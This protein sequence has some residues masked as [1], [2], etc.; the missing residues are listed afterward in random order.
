[1]SS[2]SSN[3]NQAPLDALADRIRAGIE[4][5]GVHLVFEDELSVIWGYQNMKPVHERSMAVKN[6]ANLYQLEV[7]V[8]ISAKMALFRGKAFS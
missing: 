1:M 3:P 2:S 5:K 4:K 6:F 8:S 7:Q